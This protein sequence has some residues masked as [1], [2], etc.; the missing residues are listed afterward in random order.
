MNSINRYRNW[1]LL[2]YFDDVFAIKKFANGSMAASSIRQ[3]RW[4][5]V[6]LD[7]FHGRQL[8]LGEVT[9]DLLDAYQSRMLADGY[10]VKY[11]R[12]SVWAMKTV[13]RHWNPKAL[14]DL[15]GTAQG[16]VNFVDADIQ[17]TLEH[18]FV[19]DYLPER[20]GIS[21]PS[22]IRQ[23]GRCLRL[24]GVFLGRPAE[25]KDLTDRC[26]G[27][28]L[29]WLVES[30][31]VRPVT[32]NGYV[33]Q[34]K[35]LWNWLAKKRV[36]EHFP[37]VEKLK[38]PEPTPICWTEPELKQ[39]YAACRRQPGHF[40]EV[41]ACK[42]WPAFHLVLWD[43]G[44]RTGAMLALKW[45]WLDLKNGFL[46]VPGEYRKGRTQSMVYPLKPETVEAL[47]SIQS[48]QRE[49]IFDLGRKDGYYFYKAYRRLV[50][51]A[52]LPYVP[53][54]CGPQKMRRTFA[55][56]IEA[57]GGNATRALKH[58]DRRVT[59]DSY[60]DPRIT[61]VD[62]ENKKLF[63]LDDEEGGAV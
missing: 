9:D 32:A 55:S 61:E 35:A 27:Q 45:E 37:T 30:E 43:S 10:S 59:E 20:V 60:L 19:N 8:K 21:S 1:T 46:T 22:T 56:F 49:R 52:K 2:R 41:P 54:K 58:R 26:V 17:G 33:K 4:C 53:H 15:R 28:F 5:I 7:G 3:Y 31:G 24:F 57:A 16:T 6:Y 13:V 36:V 39:L 12:N 51:D 40:G 25:T 44:E 23:Y 48:P 63:P 34:V 14:P 29:R 42:F 47:N 38:Q 50:K 18:I 11:V 62:S